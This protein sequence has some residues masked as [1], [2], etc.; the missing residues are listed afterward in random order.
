ME[1]EAKTLPHTQI[2]DESYLTHYCIVRKDLP[3]GVVC[4]QLCHAAGE[5]SPGNLPPNT[6]AVVL[7]ARSENELERLSVRLSKNNINHMAIRE[8]DSPWNGALMAIGIVPVLDRKP[9]RKLLSQL[10]LFREV[11]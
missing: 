1:K 2:H 8:P 6:R 5:S 9:V 11:S 10:P 3:I 4:A 7:A